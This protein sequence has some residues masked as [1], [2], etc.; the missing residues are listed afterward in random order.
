MAS[1]F[2]MTSTFILQLLCPLLGTH[3]S[4]CPGEGLLQCMCHSLWPCAASSLSC[5]LPL[6]RQNSILHKRMKFMLLGLNFT[7]WLAPSFRAKWR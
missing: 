6:Q 2:S 5:C 1:L 4:G 3:S 7:L